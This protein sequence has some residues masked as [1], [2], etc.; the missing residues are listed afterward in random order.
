LNDRLNRGPVLRRRVFTDPQEEL[1]GRREA[2][3][4][5]Q[6]SNYYM[7]AA[8]GFTR[9]MIRARRLS[10]DPFAHLQGLNARTD[11]RRER[12]SLPLEDFA[13]LLAATRSS[14]ETIRRL[15]GADRVVLYYLAARTGLRA[16]E[17]ASLTE[18]SFDLDADLPTVEIEAGDEKAR[19]GGVLPLAAE[20][21]AE[22][23]TWLVGRQDHE[24]AAIPLS[25]RKPETLWPGSWQHNAAAM[26]RVDMESSRT[27]WIKEADDDAAERER[28]EKS[29]QLKSVDADGLVYDFHALRG[30]VHHRPGAGW[31]EPA[32]R[33][34][35]RPALRPQADQ[36]ALH[37]PVDGG[38]VAIRGKAARDPRRRSAGPEGDRHG[39]PKYADG[40][41]HEGRSGMQRCAAKRGSGGAGRDA[42]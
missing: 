6:T 25:G 19:R 38:P 8:K 33:H 23:R 31:G 30:A 24:P 40:F 1:A 11:R 36:P 28:R 27:A 32:R 12:R 21:A 3:M 9:W 39:R 13:R 29:D 35:A 14:Q 5:T 4:S 20:L 15:T 34:E 7:V 22:L 17:L 10:S 18:A 16:S 37:P 2:G 41:A 26:L 42:S